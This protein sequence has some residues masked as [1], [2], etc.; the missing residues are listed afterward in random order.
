MNFNKKSEFHVLVAKKS[1]K[2][3]WEVDLLRGVAVTMMIVFHILYDLN[4]F[5]IYKISLYSG[6][7]LIYVYVGA[8]IFI[9]LVGLSLSLSYSRI[10]NKLSKKELLLKYPQRGLMIFGLG[11]LITLATWLY[12]GEGFVVFGALHCIGISIILAYPFLQLRYLNLVIGAI[13]I[14]IGI[15]LKS[16]VFDFPWLVWLGFRP[17]QFYTVDYFPLLPWFGVVLIGI[18][19]GNSLYSNY[20]RQFPLKDLS[21]T[22]VMRFVG[23]LGRHSLIIYLVHQPILLVL[24]SILFGVNIYI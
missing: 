17:S 12:L 14:I 5:D 8:S 3:F 11:L 15:I 6:Y 20:S 18:F 9:G 7:F 22:C 2:R 10:K 16:I 21:Q 4:H 13:L 1:V 23:L 19:V 24:I